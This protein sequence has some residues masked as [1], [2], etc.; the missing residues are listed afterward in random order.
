MNNIEEILKKSITDVEKMNSKEKREYFELLREYCLKIGEKYNSNN[1]TLTQKIMSKMGK[2]LR[3]FDYEIIGKENV[4]KD[5]CLMMC[6]HSN[7][8]DAFLAAEVL[9]EIGVPSTFIAAIEGLSPIELSLFKSAR[10]TMIDRTDKVSA[11]NGLYDF[12][13]K[14]V[15]GDTG[16]I[17][18][19]STWNLHP[20]KPM[21]NI[22]IGGSKIAAIANVPIVPMIY[23]YVEVPNIVSKEKKLYSKCIIKIGEPIYIDPSISLIE[24]TKK[25]QIIMEDMRRKMW[26][27]LGTYRDKIEDINPDIY[28]NHTWLKKFGTPLFNFDSESENKLLYTKKDELVENE[29]CIDENGIFKPGIIKKKS[30]VKG[31]Y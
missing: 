29:Y 23:E 30:K 17:Y 27:E 24:Q 13:S 9:S 7:T 19:E 12:S 5:G 22:K 28:V 8:H 20:Y 15:Y 2:L 18:G 14:L 21:Q 3:N 31:I 11:S 1:I 26:K 25:I 16:V 10:A 4:P 6:N